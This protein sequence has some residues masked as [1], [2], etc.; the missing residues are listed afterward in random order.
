MSF[1]TTAPRAA[2]LLAL[3]IAGAARRAPAGDSRIGERIEDAAFTDLDGKR[4]RLSDFAER[5]AVVVALRDPA[6][7]ESARLGEALAALE[8]SEPAARVLFLYANLAGD[9]TVEQ[10]RADQKRFGFTGRYVRDRDGALG[11]TLRATRGAE[12]FLLDYERKLRYRGALDDLKEAIDALLENGRV[13]VKETDAQG[14]P[15]EFHPPATPDAPP[16]PPVWHGTVDRIVQERCQDCHRPKGAGPF[17]LLDVD[18]AAGRERMIHRVVA[19]RVMPPWLASP[20]SGPFLHD[21]RLSPEQ[22]T[23][24]LQW[25]QAGCPEG[26]PKNAT[27]PRTFKEGWLIQPDFIVESS[28]PFHVPASGVIDYTKS[29]SDFVMPERA[30]VRGI[31]IQPSCPEVVHHLAVFVSD[32]D[33][34][35]STL[36][37]GYLPGKPPTIY[38]D[39]VAKLVKKGARF[40]FSTHYTTNGKACDNTLRVGLMLAKEP[41]KFRIAGFYVRNT[42]FT[43]PPGV[44]DYPI[45]AEEELPRD[46]FMLRFI[47]HMH[48]RGKSIKI[49]LIKPDGTTLVPLTIARWNQDW[50]FGY[51]FAS[52]PPVPKGTVIRVTSVFDNSKENPFNPDPNALVRQGPQI[53]DEMA[54]SWVEWMAPYRKAEGEETGERS[55]EKDASSGGK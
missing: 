5:D 47:P 46:A 31:Q 17:S 29:E 16:P 10:C 42:D 7:P 12:L 53:W 38:Q 8:K 20:D 43:I 37:D 1:A 49:E 18:G 26:D 2:A 34:D 39:G 36:L 21:L 44:R 30:W 6:A 41:P 24:L 45:V 3:L 14:A 13:V 50:Q 51:E 9:A 54:E 35:F 23:T 32:P 27:P 22:R 52:P 15:L 19:D 55:A 40:H 48:L 25:L 28:K 33:R 4:G 11:W